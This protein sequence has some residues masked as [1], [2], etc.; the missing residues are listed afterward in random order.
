MKEDLSAWSRD[1]LSLKIPTDCQARL[2]LMVSVFASSF[3]GNT[4]GNIYHSGVLKCKF[5]ECFPPFVES[6]IT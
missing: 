4:F 3:A 6:I 1:L 5:Q 2:M